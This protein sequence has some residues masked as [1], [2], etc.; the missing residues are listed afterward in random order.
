MV[1]YLRV[2]SEV[3]VNYLGFR[4]IR[5]KRSECEAISNKEVINVLRKMNNRKTIQ[6]DGIA[7]NFP[8][9]SLGGV[10]KCMTVAR[11]L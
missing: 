6:M 1:L 8:T 9:D 2:D 5:N 3:E 7:E 10:V 4:G 11:V